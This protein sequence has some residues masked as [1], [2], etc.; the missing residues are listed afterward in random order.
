[1][2]KLRK[3]K[4]IRKKTNHDLDY[5]K[6]RLGI[7]VREDLRD[8]FREAVEENNDTMTNVLVDY[9]EYYI[10]ETQKQSNKG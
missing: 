6:I 7:E 9:M 2:P 5:K 10:K 1:M 4:I 3:P 8:K